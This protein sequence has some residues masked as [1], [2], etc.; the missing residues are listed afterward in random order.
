MTNYFRLISSLVLEQCDVGG[1]EGGE[2]IHV[3][4][5]QDFSMP[6]VVTTTTTTTTTSTTTTTTTTCATNPG[7]IYQLISMIFLH[8]SFL[9]TLLVSNGHHNTTTTITKLVAQIVCYHGSRTQVSIHVAVAHQTSYLAPDTRI[10]TI[11][12]S[13]LPNSEQLTTSLGCSLGLTN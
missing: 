13:Q 3:K 11:L 5:R 10:I 4:M 6:I 9:Y 7:N 2:E 8:G 1:Q 12:N